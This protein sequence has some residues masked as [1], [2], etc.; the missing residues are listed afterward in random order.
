MSIRPTV[1][2][3]GA[4]A[5]NPYGGHTWVLLQY[6][7][8][9]RRLGFDV[10][11]VDR[12]GQ[13]AHSRLRSILK[14][15]DFHDRFAVLNGETRRSLI[16]AARSSA[17]LIN[18]MG[19]LND[20]ELLAAA[21]HRLFLDIDPGF[22]QMWH[23]LGQADI[24]SGHDTYFTYGANVGRPDCAVPSCGYDWI[25]TRPPVVL[26]HWPV[27]RGNAG[28]TTVGAWRGP[29][30]PIV[31]K[32]IKYGLRAH[33]FRKFARLPSVTGRPFEIALDIHPADIEDR[34]LLEEGGWSLVE[35]TKVVGNADDYRRYIQRSSAE[36]GVAKNMYVQARTGWFSDRSACY[37]AS[38]KPVLFEDTGIGSLYPIGEG[39]LTY[40][41]LEEAAG[42]VE[43]ICRDYGR[44][45]HVARAIAEEYFDSD[46][47]L[48]ALL[49]WAGD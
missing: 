46:T 6:M 30:D 40:S 23:E 39:L 26:E 13:A 4:M 22:G 43:E 15:F 12:G 42:N 34:Q 17:L 41:T 44:H 2:I 48:S 3:A 33:E 47:V 28:F 16:D 18:V 24:L 29:F 45:S 32:G 20:E 35:P 25:A 14:P 49:E 19:Y 37:L 8:G 36:F 10:L 21:R 27:A 1:L 38:G 31:Y 5:V 9:F 7:L 11:F